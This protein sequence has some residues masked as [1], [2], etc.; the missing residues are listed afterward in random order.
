MLLLQLKSIENA[1]DTYLSITDICIY[2]VEFDLRV[3]HVNNK[4][5]TL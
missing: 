2:F 1:I 3:I 5:C 4:L